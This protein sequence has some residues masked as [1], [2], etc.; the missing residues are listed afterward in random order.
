MGLF[1]FFSSSVY[2]LYHY[3]RICY[4]DYTILMKMTKICQ[5]YLKKEANC[6]TNNNLLGNDIDQYNVWFY[7]LFFFKYL[8]M[9]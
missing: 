6:Y 4:F 9:L 5:F 7:F 2:Y 3:T 8:K 1:G